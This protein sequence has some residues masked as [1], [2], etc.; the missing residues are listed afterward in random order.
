MNPVRKK[1]RK[2]ILFLIKMNLMKKY[3]DFIKDEN[4]NQYYESYIEKIDE[5]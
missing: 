1:W 3:F 2:I 5:I 4:N